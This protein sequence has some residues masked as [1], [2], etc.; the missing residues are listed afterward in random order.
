MNN[1]IT[2]HLSAIE[3]QH[4][5]TE[6]DYSENM[7][8]K[9]HKLADLASTRTSSS[10]V[11]SRI[12]K[13]GLSQFKGRYLCFKLDSFQAIESLLNR[14]RLNMPW[15]WRNRLRYYIFG[16]TYTSA[17]HDLYLDSEPRI[18]SN[19][20]R[21]LRIIL[22]V[23]AFQLQTATLPISISFNPIA[24]CQSQIFKLC[25]EGNIEM[26][27]IWF[28]NS[29]AS[30]FV[31]NQHGE[32]LLHVSVI[33]SFPTKRLSW[34]DRSEIRPCRTMPSLARRRS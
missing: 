12:G 14:L 8:A 6:A 18:L 27:K 20:K 16:L 10:I 33:P 29:W 21:R 9:R 24:P 13:L 34:K 31:V 4:K 2:K 23:V 15:Q 32:N 11:V 25:L 19:V 1:N 3:I 30:P 26:V 17:T 5:T 7:A 28:T 22:P